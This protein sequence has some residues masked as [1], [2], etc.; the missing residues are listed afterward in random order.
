MIIRHY[1]LGKGEEV[2]LVVMAKLPPEGDL[3]GKQVVILEN[4]DGDGEIRIKDAESGDHL[5]STA[6][7]A[8]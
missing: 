2:E 6:E 4:M 5:Y 8:K 7:Q 3:N 1:N